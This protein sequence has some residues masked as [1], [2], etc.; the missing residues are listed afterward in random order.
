MATVR[1]TGVGV[2]L[3]V[4]DREQV[5]R[6]RAGVAGIES[7]FASTIAVTF[8]SG[9]RMIMLEKPLIPPPCAMRRWPNVAGDG[10]AIDQPYA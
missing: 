3:P 9:S 2:R 4:V 7:V 10:G 6:H 8:L 5:A 1:G